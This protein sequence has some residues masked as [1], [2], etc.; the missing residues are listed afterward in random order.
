ML[1][2]AGQL[3]YSVYRSF[4]DEKSCPLCLEMSPVRAVKVWALKLKDVKLSIELKRT[5]VGYDPLS[6][7]S[8]KVIPFTLHSVIIKNID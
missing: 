5:A 8:L 2:D 3:A 4:F 6:V 7:L 1:F